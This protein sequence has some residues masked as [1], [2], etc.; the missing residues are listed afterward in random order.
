MALFA[1]SEWSSDDNDNQ[2]DEKSWSKECLE[3]PKVDGKAKKSKK[4]KKKKHKEEAPPASAV[5]DVKSGSAGEENGTSQT[6]TP[7]PPGSLLRMGIK[8]ES[9]ELRIE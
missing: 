2:A 6:D 9:G 5:K 1:T 3:E 4:K 8:F 7:R